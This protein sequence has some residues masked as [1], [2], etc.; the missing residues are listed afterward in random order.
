[1]SANWIYLGSG[2]LRNW[3]I[4]FLSNFDIFAFLGIQQLQLVQ[5]F[6][7][8]HYFFSSLRLPHRNDTK[9]RFLTAACYILAINFLPKAYFKNLNVVFLSIN[10]KS[11]LKFGKC[12]LLAELKLKMWKI[13]NLSTFEFELGHERAL[14]KCYFISSTY[15]HFVLKLTFRFLKDS[16]GVIGCHYA[17]SL[18]HNTH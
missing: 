15:R 11:A 13:G 8:L 1:M 17:Y 5:Q 9:S 3:E 7:H 16:I 10:A 12:Y 6:R 4:D 2:K 14:F 18:G